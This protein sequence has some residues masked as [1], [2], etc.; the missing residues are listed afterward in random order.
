MYIWIVFQLTVFLVK[1]WFQFR[2]SI[3]YKIKLRVY[4]IIERIIIIYI[5]TLATIALSYVQVTQLM[6]YKILATLILR[7]DLILTF[8]K[9]NHMVEKQNKM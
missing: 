6:M 2:I 4:N 7:H 8:K 1:N 5:Q 9:Q 3:P